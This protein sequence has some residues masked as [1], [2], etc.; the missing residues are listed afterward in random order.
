M[1]QTTL[2]L[3]ADGEG[4]FN[5]IAEFAEGQESLSDVLEMIDK[6]EPPASWILELHN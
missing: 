4:I 3:L 1:T 2:H 6:Y 5:R